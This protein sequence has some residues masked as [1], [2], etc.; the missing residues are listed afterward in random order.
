MA[1]NKKNARPDKYLEFINIAYQMGIIIAGGVI[2]GIWLDKKYPNKYSVFTI[3]FSLLG[4]FI[5]L[6]QV[7]RRVIQM[8]K[9]D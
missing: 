1:K 8:S 5:A 9:D 6:F 2:L 4:V 7:T 3:G